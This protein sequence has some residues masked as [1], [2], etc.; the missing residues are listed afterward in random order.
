MARSQIST[1]RLTVSGKAHELQQGSSGIKDYISKLG[2]AIAIDDDDDDDDDG[3]MEKK[4][5]HKKHEVVF[6]DEYIG[7]KPKFIKTM[8]FFLSWVF[9]NCLSLY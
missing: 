8:R 6:Y 4:S 2:F 9:L 3:Y 7:K 1:R 5:L